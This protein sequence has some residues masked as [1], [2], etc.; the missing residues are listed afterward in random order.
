[1]KRGKPGNSTGLVSLVGGMTAVA[2]LPGY[3]TITGLPALCEN[4]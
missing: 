2:E 3:V 4:G 1:M